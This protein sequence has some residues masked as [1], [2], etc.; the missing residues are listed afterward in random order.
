MS[1]SAPILVTGASKG[2]GAAVA[3]RLAESGYDIWLNYRSDHDGAAAVAGRI[4]ALGRKCVV[5]PFDVADE[6]AMNRALEPLLN[7]ETPY[8]LVH[9]A[10]ITR[11]SLLAMMR[12]EDWDLVLNVHLTGF[13]LVGRLIVK[14]M[15]AA[16]RGRI[17]AIAST[18]GETGQA[19]QFN[20]AAAK[21]GMIAAAKAL[22]REVAKRNILVNVVSP[23]LIDTEMIEGLPLD[24]MLAGVPLG[25]VGKP[26]EVAAAVDF[27]MSDGAGY[28][29]GQVL[30]V[31]GGLYI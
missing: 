25:R 21:G 18:T 9:N 28:I 20:Y 23:G 3:V 2:I 6:E 24:K 31:N 7:E 12:R 26:E 1:E 14:S 29:T 13:F 8:G 17:V 11:D 5:V 27:L 15:I 4:E 10:G 30:S 22:A 16:R 19:G